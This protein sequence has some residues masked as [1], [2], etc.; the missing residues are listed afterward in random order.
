MARKKLLSE[1][2]IERVKSLYPQLSATALA[3][4]FGVS[5]STIRTIVGKK[6]SVGQVERQ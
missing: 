4:R 6:K 1:Q 5:V 2:Q 3:E